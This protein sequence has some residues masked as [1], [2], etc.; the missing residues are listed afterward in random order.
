MSEYW[1][2]LSAAAVPL[3]PTRAKE[4]DEGETVVDGAVGPDWSEHALTPMASSS[5][6]AARW[7][8]RI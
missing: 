1:R 3:P 7:R 4:G 5:V 8:L 2:L 6:A